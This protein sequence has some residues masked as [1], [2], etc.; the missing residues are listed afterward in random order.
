M[1]YLTVILIGQFGG[2]SS[3]CQIKITANTIVLSQVLMMNELIRQ[4]KYPPICFSSQ[5]AKLNVRQMYHSYGRYICIW[6]NTYII[7]IT[8]KCNIVVSTQI[9]TTFCISY[10]KTTHSVHLMIPDSHNFIV[11]FLL[12]YRL[13]PRTFST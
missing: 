3:S 6:H 10:D 8:T 5:I 2:F 1:V 13:L 4:T 9:I 11:V 7:I 12:Y